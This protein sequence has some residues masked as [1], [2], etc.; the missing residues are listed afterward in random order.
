[1]SGIFD[2]TAATDFV[3][4]NTDGKGEATFTVTNNSTRSLRAQVRLRPLEETKSEWLSQA[5]ETE[6]DFTP[7]ATRQVVITVQAPAAILS[8]KYSFRIDIIPVDNPDEDYSEGP[9]VTLRCGLPPQ[10]TRPFPWLRLIALSAAL[11]LICALVYLLIPKKVDVPKVINLSFVDAEKEIVRRGLIVEKIIKD[12]P[13]VIDERVLDQDPKE[14]KI[15]KGGIIKLIVALPLKFD[16][17]NFTGRPFPEASREIAGIGLLVERV[18]R[19]D[20]AVL[21]ETVIDQEPREGKI[22]KGKAIKLIIGIPAPSFTMPDFA[23]AGKNIKDAEEFFN[24]RYVVWINKTAVENDTEREGNVL[25]QHPDKNE[26]VKAGGAINLTFAVPSL[27]FPMPA[28][29]GKHWAA[30][31]I[32]LENKGIIV[33]LRGKANTGQQDEQI[34]EQDPPEGKLI[35]SGSGVTLI[36]S[37]SLINVPVVAGR[38]W[39]DAQKVLKDSALMLFEVRG[40]CNKP[41][42]DTD[43]KTDAPVSKGSYVSLYTPGDRQKICRKE[44][45]LWSE[46]FLTSRRQ[47]FIDR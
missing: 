45:L 5:G 6:Y 21:V 44:V 43:P 17:P 3:Q 23:G 18:V 22:T 46:R 15:K 27:P 33:T 25:A 31:T 4:L 41:V 20:P 40:D 37:M 7:N 12:D 42:E 19:E 9:I 1:V 38:T 26:Q 24:N 2:L 36:V 34:V 11:V 8:G 14:G 28:V 47:R 13:D 29:T 32:E 30:S 10:P 35:K 39:Q 16:V